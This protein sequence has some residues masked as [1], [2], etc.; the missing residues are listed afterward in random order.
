[1]APNVNPSDAATLLGWLVRRS[2]AFLFKPLQRESGWTWVLEENDEQVRASI[3]AKG[4]YVGALGFRHRW[5]SYRHSI[6][7]SRFVALAIEGS[8]EQKTS[9][10]FRNPLQ[11]LALEIGKRLIQLESRLDD[12]LKHL[13]PRDKDGRVEWAASP[14]GGL[15]PAAPVSDKQV[16]IKLGHIPC[17]LRCSFCTRSIWPEDGFPDVFFLHSILYRVATS[18]AQ[19]PNGEGKIVIGSGEPSRFPDLVSI[20]RLAR[21][22]GY[23]SIAMESAAVGSLT[24]QRISELA[25]SGLTEVDLPLYGATD[26][27]HDAV[28]GAPGHL[29]SI[30]WAVNEFSRAGVRVR[31]HGIPLTTNLKELEEIPVWT[32]NRGVDF[33]SFNFPLN[34]GESRIP[35]Q[36]LTPRLSDLPETIRPLLNLTIPCLGI[37]K[38]DSGPFAK[39]DSIELVDH[40]GRQVSESYQM[41]FA[42]VCAS[43]RAR[44]QCSGVF[45][46]YLDIHGE[47][48]FRAL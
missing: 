48:E 40:E 41:E 31:M 3:H 26:A 35:L 17:G 7:D 15:K 4:K 6:I 19:A 12:L 43:C 33:H 21:L 47:G 16:A 14:L 25:S 36:E 37:G 8:P 22:R 20:V 23:N 42:S 46:G 5:P 39:I 32:F 29:Q 1:M 10:A 28:V 27:V 34:Q 44:P 38:T 45:K 24:A 2:Q 9:Q 13:F 30:D 18:L 11:Q